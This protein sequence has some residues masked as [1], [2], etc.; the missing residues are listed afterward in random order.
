DKTGTL[1]Q[2]KMTTQHVYVDGQML[3]CKSMDFSNLAQKRLMDIAVLANDSTITDGKPIGDPTEFALIDLANYYQIE[4]TT[5]RDELPRLGE[6]PFD[7]DRK[8][9]STAHIIGGETVLLTKG[10]VDVLL[11]RSDKIIKQD[12]VCPITER[13]KEAILNA[14]QHFSENG[15][16]VLCFAYKPISD[17]DHLDINDE[18]NYIFAGLI[19]LVDPPREESADA[20]KKAR[21]A[22][23]KTIMITGDHKVTASAIAKQIG[24]MEDGD[25]ALTGLELD[26]MDDEELSENLDKISVYARVSPE[27]KIRIVGL[28]QKKGRIVAMTGDGVNDAPA[29]TKADIG[30][31]MGITGTEVS[32]DAAAMI[33]TD[34][35]FATIVKAVANGRN[36]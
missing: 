11:D 3:D 16:R 4:E 12:G 24:I 31:A 14:N 10:A 18:Q 28:W 20:V 17:P 9:M 33:L 34:D 7:S 6:I 29:L 13:D 35:N 5:Y 30:I 8:L 2:N 1:T 32:K 36:V 27:H 21:N 26:E 15:L 23:I 25:I 19:S 22:G